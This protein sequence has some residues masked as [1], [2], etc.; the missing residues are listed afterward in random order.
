MNDAKRKHNTP[1]ATLIKNYT[2]KGSGKVCSSRKEIIKRFFGVDWRHQKQILF[3]FLQSGMSDRKWAY[4]KLFA[5][6]DDCFIP[7]LKDLWEQ[8][9]ERE[10]SWLVIR[11]FPTDYLKREIESLS[12]GRNYYFLY[13]RLRDDADFVL[14]RTR[15]DEA[16]LLAVKYEL[17]ET[18]TDGYVMDL[19]FL[20]IYKLCKGV[21]NFRAWSII[22]YLGSDAV[23]TIFCSSKVEALINLINARLERCSLAKMIREWMYLV[24]CDFTNEYGDDGLF[25]W[26]IEENM[27]WTMKKVCLKH[28]APDYISAW[29][30]FPLWDQQR[31]LDYLENRNNWHVQGEM[32]E[33]Q[34]RD[35]LMKSLLESS[36]S[37][38]LVERFDLEIVDDQ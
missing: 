25:F 23:L 26:G 8:Y 20:L 18:I 29:D 27:Q 19:F 37:R 11:F 6:W 28:I 10:L 13:Q 17:G 16:D 4:K 5:F 33:T 2:N 30:R 31:F 1:I 38:Q 15:L 22:G 9:H 34:T 24:T 32:S 36:C 35:E 21:Y 3:A 7:V 12:E 14:D